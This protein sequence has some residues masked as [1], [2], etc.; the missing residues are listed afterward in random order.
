MVHFANSHDVGIEN[1]MVHWELIEPVV[2]VEL[3]L[4]L[5]GAITVDCLELRLF[6]EHE[7]E[8]LLHR[9]LI[10]FDLR[11]VAVLS[12]VEDLLGPLDEGFDDGE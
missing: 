12:V 7:L 9:V 5:G 3:C 11:G 6:L 1:R 2:E 10:F 8:A 4:C